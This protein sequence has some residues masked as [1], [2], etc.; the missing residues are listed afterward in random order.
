MANIDPKDLLATG[1]HFGH[2]TSNWHPKMAPYIYGVRGEVHIIDLVK[3]A[4][5]FEEALD[6]VTKTVAAGKE[7][8]LV[9]TKRQAIDIIRDT[10]KSTGQ[11]YVVERWLGG[12]LTNWQTMTERI[13]KMK[14][15]EE[16]M[17]SGE[18]DAKYNKLEVLRYQQEIDHLNHVFGGVREMKGAP[19]LVFVVD[20][21]KEDTAIKEAKK[22]GIPVIGIA[23]T[24]VNPSLVD[25]PIPAN[26]DAIKTIS[27]VLDKIAAAINEGKKGQKVSAPK[28]KS[29]AKIS[30]EK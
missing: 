2:K 22:L 17:E 21:K 25:F 18:L 1:A 6:E 16:Q 30:E 28:E 14:K 7:V 5:M 23:D 15:L 11:P 29:E 4:S 19:G 9:G 20:I 24:N 10:A 26:D 12:M 3:T 13:K 27:F 8:L